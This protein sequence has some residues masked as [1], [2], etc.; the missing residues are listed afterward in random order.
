MKRLNLLRM[1]SILLFVTLFT[2]LIGFR[3]QA[4]VMDNTIPAYGNW[5]EGLKSIS[6]KGPITVSID[7]G[8]IT[9][10]S[11]SGRS[12][13][14]INISNDSGFS[15]KETVPSDNTSYIIIDL[16]NAPKGEYR[17]DL[18][19]QWGDHLYGDFEIR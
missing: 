16:S 10:Q 6:I 4:R 8:L 7:G 1:F 2:N 3:A 12:D 15:Y 9:I 19:N 18:T 11:T 17:L 13:I 14:T 5:K